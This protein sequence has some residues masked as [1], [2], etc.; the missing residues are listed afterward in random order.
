MYI[1]TYIY[2]YTHN[3]Y[4][5]VYVYMYIYI[6]IH[7]RNVYWLSNHLQ[8]N[9]CQ[10]WSTMFMAFSISPQ[11]IKIGV[12]PSTHQPVPC[13][14]SAAGQSAT[15]QYPGGVRIG[16]HGPDD[17]R[18]GCCMVFYCSKTWVAPAVRILCHDLCMIVSS[19]SLQSWISRILKSPH[20]IS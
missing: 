16:I 18:R 11:L 1:Y 2:I 13:R 5:Y 6:Y 12:K 7:V 20:S 9:S 10:S 8:Q 3:I 15:R 17:D 14:R 19:G 4:I